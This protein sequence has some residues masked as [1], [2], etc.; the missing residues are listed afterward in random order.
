MGKFIIN[1]RERGEFQFDFVDE[2]GE[3]ILSSGGYTRKFMCAK[4]IESVKINSQDNTKYFRKTSPDDQRYFNLKAFNGKTIGSS[5]MYKDKVLRDEGI[6]NFKKDAP[7]APIEDH[8]NM[9]PEY[10]L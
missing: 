9:I 5:K 1:K 4:G 2:S 6:E 8:C 3:I 7:D 10:S